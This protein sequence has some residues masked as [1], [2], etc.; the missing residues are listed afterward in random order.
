MTIFQANVVVPQC[1]MIGTCMLAFHFWVS[2][3]VDVCDKISTLVEKHTVLLK[4]ADIFKGVM[5]NME[6][7]QTGTDTKSTIWTLGD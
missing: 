4:N 5:K 7:G 2:L 6:V 1:S 3:V